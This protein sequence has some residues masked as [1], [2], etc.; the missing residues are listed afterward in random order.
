MAAAVANPARIK[1][2]LVNTAW[3]WLPDDLFAH[4]NYG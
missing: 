3:L 1:Q 4:S 2:I